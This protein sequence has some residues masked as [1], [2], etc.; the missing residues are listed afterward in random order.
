MNE[1]G[2]KASRKNVRSKYKQA[3]VDF[4]DSMDG[5]TFLVPKSEHKNE[6]KA[7]ERTADLEE[8]L[9]TSWKLSKYEMTTSEEIE[10]KR[11]NG[12]PDS[13]YWRDFPIYTNTIT[14]HYNVVL[15]TDGD[16]VLFAFLG[17]KRLKPTTL[18]T[19]QR[20]FTAKVEKYKRQLA[21]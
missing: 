14:Y 3:V 10:K 5:R 15:S 20:K 17:K 1:E 13:Y 11:L 8:A 7:A 6:K 16:A 18:D 19:M 21:K 12:D 4:Y 9:K 2:D